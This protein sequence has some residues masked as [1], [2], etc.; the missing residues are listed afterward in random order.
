M[1]GFDWITHLNN[2]SNRVYTP[3]QANY[4]MQVY[5]Y[6]VNRYNANF[7]QSVD[8]LGLFAIQESLIDVLDYF[9][10]I[11]KTYPGEQAQ[12]ALKGIGALLIRLSHL[13]HNGRIETPEE[14]WALIINYK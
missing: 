10:I 2:R 7:Y 12:N 6:E 13:I 5:Q 3:E 4:F 11:N 9:T 8:R 14:Y 1:K